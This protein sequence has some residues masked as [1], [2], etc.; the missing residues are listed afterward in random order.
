MKIPQTYLNENALSYKDLLEKYE[1]SSIK[2]RTQKIIAAEIFKTFNNSNPSYMK[3]I[4]QQQ[5]TE[6]RT[7]QSLNIKS[8]TYSSKK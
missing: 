8:Q 1:K 5:S 7:R 6:R 2:Y 4:F 3:D